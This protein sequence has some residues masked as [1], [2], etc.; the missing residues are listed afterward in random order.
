MDSKCLNEIVGVN[1]SVELKIFVE[2]NY[3]EMFIY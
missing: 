3:P 1:K 2:L